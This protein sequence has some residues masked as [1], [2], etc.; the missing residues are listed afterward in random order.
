MYAT[1]AVFLTSYFLPLLIAPLFLN[2][3]SPLSGSCLI[4]LNWKLAISLLCIFPTSVTSGSC[5]FIFRE[6]WNLFS[7][8]KY[9][10]LVALFPA[11]MTLSLHLKWIA[12]GFV[13]WTNIL[14]CHLSFDYQFQL[15][16]GK[17][18]K[19][20]CRL[21]YY[22]FPTPVL[23][24]DSANFSPFSPAKCIISGAIL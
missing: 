5:P 1:L 9:P 8:M 22:H 17:K 12:N 4:T 3:Q 15:F 24:Y 2:V 6:S 14:N 18:S 13:L 11:K 19:I 16:C 7:R 23:P 21:I 20:S 10:L